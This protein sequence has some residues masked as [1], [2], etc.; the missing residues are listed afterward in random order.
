MYANVIVDIS[1]EKLDKTFQYSIPD[2]LLCDIRPGV[3][4]DIP[5]GSRT[6]TGYV[7]EV[8]DKPEY[9][10]ARTK[11]LIGIKAD[12]VAVEAKLIA[13]AAWIR[14]NYGSTMNQAL[15]TVIPVKKQAKEQVSRSIA[16]KIDKVKA[17]AQLAL[18]EAKKQKAKA[19]LFRALIDADD[20]ASLEYSFVTGK[21][22]VSAATIRALEQS[23]F[24]EVI[25]QT[26]YRNPVEHMSVDTY[27]KV[28]NAA[29]QS[30]VD[31]IEG[32]IAAG[33]RNTYLIKGVTGSGKT[34]VYME[35][36]AHCIQS[37]R[38]AIVLIPEIALTYQ[39]VMRFFA[40]F[41]NRVSIIN[42][43]LSN[44]ERYDQFER[45]KN[46]DIDIMIGPR[47]AL[48]TP[49]SNLGLII[50]DEEHENSYKSESVPRYHAREVAIEYARMSDAIVVLGSATPSVDSYYKAKTG[51][52]RLLELDKRVDDRPLPK[53]EVVDLRQELREGN[54]SIL[55]TRLQELMEERLLNGQQ[56][57]LFLNR[58][59]KSAFMSCRACGFVVKCPHCD[60]SLSEHSGGVMV[61]HYC[62]Y[63]QPVP[64]VCPSCGSKYISGFKAG[65]QKIEAMVAKRFPQARILRMDYDTTRAKD[66]Y[67]KILQAFSNH[68]A[69]I[70]IGTQMIVK[71]HD[72][73]NVTLVG[74]LAA[75]MSLH[76]ND[77]HAAERTFALLTQAAGRAGRGKLPGNVV[78]Q[79][80][81]PDH[82]AIQ[83][84]KEQDYE[85]FYDKEIEYRR[86]M[87]YPPVWNMLLV[88]VTSPDESECGSMAQRVYDIAA[89]M[90]S[91][92]DENQSP[93][94][95]H[96]IQLIG[97]A[98][99][100][101]AKVNDIYRKVIYMKTSDYAAL[102]SIK[103]GI[104]QAVKADTAMKNANISFDFNPMS[105]F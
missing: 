50:I 66:A 85:A 61:C 12:S 8:T 5:F 101:I 45:A 95:R 41:G 44:G 82:Y 10:T 54:R 79:T 2:E 46:G 9:D 91:H 78:I 81:D 42:S 4:V 76:V 51:V 24:I 100:T 15:K 96:R 70:L 21:L 69:D 104:E 80:Y 65:T 39:T 14:R 22:S 59:G 47:S 97:P 89:Q 30:V 31:A 77:F 90:I 11:P 99:A 38:Q 48:F 58:R 87:N 26:G 7:I 72:F 29:Q 52:Y 84:A 60:V 94:D 92:T 83:T 27:D 49:F 67:E 37:A 74:V 40:R 88:H 3:C 18:C 1:H 43:R 103:D 13:L 102:I 19:R 36:I 64:K 55:S 23:G 17:R 75:D 16:L 93:D 63:R 34:E 57:M 53:C 98:D 32:D 35:L 6:I 56:T 25:T 73:S 62:G 71:G 33:L 105:G 28:L 20:G 68:E 86:L